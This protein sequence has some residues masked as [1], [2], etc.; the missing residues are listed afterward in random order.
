[1][2]AGDRSPFVCRT[3]RLW[4][5]AGAVDEKKR[6]AFDEDVAGVPEGRQQRF[7]V[8]AVVLLV[9]DLRQKDFIVGAVPASC[10]ILIGPAEAEG[11]VRLS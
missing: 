7:D 1:M 11:K 3:G 2:A 8:V 9:V 5:G 4:Q 6:S 10:P